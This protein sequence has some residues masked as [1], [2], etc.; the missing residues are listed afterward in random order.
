MSGLKTLSISGMDCDYKEVDSKGNDITQ[1]WMIKEIPGKIR[2]LKNLETLQLTLNAISVIPPEIS[3][4][5]NL[6]SI[7]LT[8]NSSLINID[9]IAKLTNLKELYLFGC[10]LTKMPND[11]ANLKNLKKLGLVGNNFDRDEQTR[12]RKA[13]PNCDIQ[14]E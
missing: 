3:E 12:I 7:D 14:L 10:N 11:L 8:D 1:C 4:L 5:T 13:L 6:K 2:D 9:A